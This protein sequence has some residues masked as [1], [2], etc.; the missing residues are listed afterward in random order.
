MQRGDTEYCVSIIPL[1]GYV[2]MAGENPEDGPSGKADEFLSKTK[3]QRFQ[4]LIAGPAMNII[5]AVVLLAVVLMQGADVPVYLDQPAAVGAVQQNSPAERAGIRPGDIITQFGTAE[6][7]T[8]EHLEMAV[9]ARP[10]R[11]V[12]V[13]VIRNGRE[14]RLKIRPDLTEM[15]TG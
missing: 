12:D 9:A 1:G 3:W 4:I 10:E 8:W 15:R 13:V 6:V 7:E 5:L 2:K 11:E 14:E